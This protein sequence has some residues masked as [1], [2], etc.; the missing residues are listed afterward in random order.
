MVCLSCN[1]SGCFK[2]NK[3]SQ[4]CANP[5]AMN[6]S[7]S[8]LSLQG[9]RGAGN[10]ISSQCSQFRRW[11]GGAGG[12][13]D[14]PEEKVP[15]GKEHL[16]RA[17]EKIE[18]DSMRYKNTNVK[19]WIDRNGRIIWP[20][21]RIFVA[22]IVRGQAFETFMGIVILLNIVLMIVEADADASCYPDHADDVLACPS[23]SANVPWI[24]VCNVVL[25][26][27]YTTECCMRAFVERE[28]YV[29]NRWN[30]LDLFTTLPGWL[31]LAMSTSVNFALFRTLRAVRLLRAG[32][33]L[34]SIPEIYILTSGLASALKPILFGSIMLLT[35]II[36]WS[37]IVV[38]FLHPT[39]VSI[40][41]GGCERCPRGFQNVYSASL[42]LFSQLVAQ[43][44]WSQLSLPLAEIAPW[45]TPLLFI[46]LMT[47]SL[48]VMNLI[49]AVVVEK[50][51]E[52]RENDQERKMQQKEKE[53]EQNMIEL[54]VLCDRMD[55]DGSGALSLKEMLHG[56]DTDVNF[57]SLMAFMD[58]ERDDMQTIFQ[59]LDSDG[60]GEVDYVEFCHHL[61]SC[62][63]RDPLMMSSLTR[64]SIMELKNLVS[65]ITT[66]I[67]K[68][69]EQNTQMLHE[70]LDLL[71][72]VPGCE[73]AA[74]E[75]KKRRLEAHIDL[76][77]P[78]TSSNG[79]IAQLSSMRGGNKPAPVLVDP[80]EIHDRMLVAGKQFQAMQLQLDGLMMK[81]EELK[82]DALLSLEDDRPSM[83]SSAKSDRSSARSDSSNLY[84]ADE[85]EAE[86]L[87]RTALQD[88]FDERF[89]ELLQKFHV[90][91]V[92]EEQMQV[93]CQEIVSS[94][95]ELLKRPMVQQ[96][97]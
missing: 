86:E 88:S 47:V 82:K 18:K 30:Q 42:T 6:R 69:L 22:K 52:A 28:N 44:S 80:D 9:A 60:S 5:S 32:R 27:I 53:R 67:A 97:L 49:L 56:F 50:A 21:S 37:I 3:L 87:R 43:D 91:Y 92:K 46:I 81:A 15:E 12:S 73:K 38:E 93:K 83:R 29:W 33:L 19:P 39:N 71:C 25:Q 78:V 2:F 10:W 7:K 58:I 75:L 51:A 62:G 17:L 65:T 26:V 31:T 57:K 85:K 23:R 96:E 89:R 40:N 48:G 77:S 68:V 90:R 1:I 4:A 34:I 74:Q 54:A 35:V 84:L 11:L 20:Q 8:I 41:Y 55:E 16:K 24:Q 13:D 76:T 45:T 72:Y 94:L 70:Q 79:L 36:L 66:D 59:V 61:G 95:A 64:Y 14:D 63:K